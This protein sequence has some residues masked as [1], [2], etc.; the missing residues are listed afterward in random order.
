MKI[1][2][3]R[4]MARPSLRIAY[5][6]SL[7]GRDLRLPFLRPEC[8]ATFF[9]L[10]AHLQGYSLCHSPA[11][12]VPLVDIRSASL[13]LPFQF[14]SLL[15]LAFPQPFGYSLTPPHI[16]FPLY[17]PL[18]CHT[19]WQMTLKSACAKKESLWSDLSPALSQSLEVLTETTRCGQS[20]E[21]LFPLPL[22]G[23]LGWCEEED[24]LLEGLIRGLNSL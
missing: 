5:S 22:P 8:P 2:S 19:S 1:I 24:P 21:G 17:I 9:A 7:L 13:Q 12:P 16:F 10:Q 11:S 18:L 23:S 4:K 14:L 6:F 15:P 20:T 3:S